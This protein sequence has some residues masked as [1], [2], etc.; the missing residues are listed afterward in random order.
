M[1]FA[2]QAK[3]QKEIKAIGRLAPLSE[4]EMNEVLADEKARLEADLN[5]RN[6]LWGP[7]TPYATQAEYQRS[8]LGSKYN[9]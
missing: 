3:K 9:Y 8:C 6:T 1:G 4:S 2:K 7:G 5:K